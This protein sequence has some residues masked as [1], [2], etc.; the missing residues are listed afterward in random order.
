ML[1]TIAYYY[2]LANTLSYVYIT[3]FF[4]CY[5]AARVLFIIIFFFRERI[6]Q[7]P[8]ARDKLLTTA[9]RNVGDTL[10]EGF[11]FSPPTGYRNSGPTL[12]RPAFPRHNVH[13][14]QRNNDNNNIIK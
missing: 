7:R 12:K 10:P 5:A 4:K 8:N 9:E 14:K 11:D 2:I 3:L 13:R 6:D 1:P